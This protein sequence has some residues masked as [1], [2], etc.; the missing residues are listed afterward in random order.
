M[1]VTVKLLP[2]PF[3]GGKARI[4]HLYVGK[5]PT[6]SKVECSK[7]HVKTDFYLYEYGERNV[8][9]VWNRRADHD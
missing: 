8:T 4:K 2:C 7:C 5:E 6:H 1:T 9:K 3:C